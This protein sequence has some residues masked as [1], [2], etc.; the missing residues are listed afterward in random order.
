MGKAI[1]NKLVGDFTEDRLEAQL[2]RKLPYN[3]QRQQVHGGSRA[4][5]ILHDDAGAA[6]AVIECKSGEF[7]DVKQARRLVSLAETTKARTLYLVTKHGDA[8]RFS[9]AVREVFR[10][11]KAEG[12]ILVKFFDIDKPRDAVRGIANHVREQLRPEMARGQSKPASPS[13]D[14]ADRLLRGR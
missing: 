9:P 1:K 2:N 12:R 14:L 7:R 13:F 8:R 4:D 5:F 6:A 10:Q 11:A 3:Y